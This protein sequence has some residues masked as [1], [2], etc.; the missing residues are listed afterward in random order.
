MH[1]NFGILETI[2]VYILFIYKRNYFRRQ[3]VLFKHFFQTLE[4]KLKIF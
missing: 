3:N 2:E 4:I 1:K